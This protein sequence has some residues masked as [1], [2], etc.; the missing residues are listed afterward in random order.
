MAE[1]NSDRAGLPFRPIFL[2]DKPAVLARRDHNPKRVFVV[3]LYAIGS[4]INPPCIR[5]FHDY[6]VARAEVIAPVLGVPEWRWELADINF[7]F[8]LPIFE[9][10][11]IFQLPRGDRLKFLQAITPGLHKLLTR[12]INRKI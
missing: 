7:V 5:I 6:N 1:R 9:N 10:R 3:D 11:S 8:G 4:R 12:E 2:P